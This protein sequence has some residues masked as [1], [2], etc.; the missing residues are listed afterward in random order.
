ME[1]KSRVL[2][3]SMISIETAEKLQSVAKKTGISRSAL[4]RFILDEYSDCDFITTKRN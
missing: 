1:K 2:V 3:Q 4:I